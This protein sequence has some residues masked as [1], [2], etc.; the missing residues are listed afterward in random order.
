MIRLG[1]D[2]HG[3]SDA[4]IP[5]FS[6]LSKLLVKNGHEV[7]ILTGSEQSPELERHL[8]EDLGLRWTHFFS[9][10]THHKERGMAIEYI[11][12][13]PFMDEETWNAT[14][15]AYCEKHG[16]QLHIDDSPVY[17]RHFKTPYAK[18]FPNKQVKKKKKI[19]I[20]G[21]SFNPITTAHLRIAEA[22]LE[23][24]PDIHQVWL[25]PAYMHPFEK[26][27]AYASNRIH[28][29]R[30]AETD[31]IRYFGYEIDNKLSGETYHTFTRLLD[32]PDY[33]NTFEFSMILGSDCA[34]EFDT[35]WKNAKRLARTISFIIV[36]RPG[37][38]LGNYNGLLSEK[39]HIV[40]HGFEGISVSATQ[41]RKKIGNG[42][43]I[44][45]LVP[46]PVERFILKHGL[47]AH[48]TDGEDEGPSKG[49]CAGDVYKAF[50]MT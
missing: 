11:G 2:I 21:G 34:L 38:D 49:A 22:A 31:K 39:P 46:E 9:I 20:L 4:D 19:A 30:L 35:R 18:Y 47:Y 37:Y 8:A 15:A 23:A 50:H 24:I 7:H 1:I 13:N 25:M 41:V 6:E 14:K 44:C 42:E 36:P 43:S 48:W 26:H 32:D 27:R 17:G 33:G 5:F 29:A 3:V 28:L 16:I 40:L 10:T 45:G 12:G